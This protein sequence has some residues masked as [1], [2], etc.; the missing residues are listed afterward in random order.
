MVTPNGPE[1]STSR[2]D[3]THR[4]FIDY[5]ERTRAHY[6][7]EGFNNPYK[8]AFYDFVPFTRLDKPVRDCRVALVTTAAEYQPDKGDQGPYAPYNDDAKFDDVYHRPIEPP[9]DL[10]I[11]HIS[12]DRANT[13]PEDINAYFPLAQMKDFA[14]RGRIGGLPSRFYA[15]PTLRSQRHTIEIDAPAILEWCREDAVDAAVLVAV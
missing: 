3:R 8:W 14:Q 6:L 4:T 1:H 12:Y 10:R 15:V 13:V 2:V 5:I 11:S 7:A 9:P